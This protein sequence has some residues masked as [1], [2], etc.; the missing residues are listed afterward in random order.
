MPASDI[1]IREREIVANRIFDA[2]RELVWRAFTDPEHLQHWWEPKGFTNTFHVF[3]LKPGG[4]WRFT[5]HGS[6]GRNYENENVFVE[7]DW[8]SRIVFDHVSDPQFRATLGFEALG[9][10]TKLTFHQ[11]FETEAA[12]EFVKPFAVP[13]L[14][15]NL[16]RLAERLPRIDPNFGELTI[17]RIFDAPRAL[18]WRAFTDPAHLAKWWGP[19]GFTNPVCEIDL[20]V[21]G[22]LHIV[23][24]GP[25]GAVSCH[26]MRGIFREI[27]P[28]TRLVFTNCAVGPND[29]VLLDGLTTIEFADRDGKTEMV[30]RT[31]ARG[32]VPGASLMI[33]GMGMGW[34]QSIDKLADFLA[35]AKVGA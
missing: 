20:K 8:L 9:E 3:E 12:F 16:E 6:D 4:L 24:Q 19:K 11:S 25:E 21:G 23:M 7:I 29:E 17:I 33:A 34:T 14:E 2:P 15:Q 18:V 13:G 27:V 32:L 10:K 26:P 5:M 31:S 1:A 28:E 22:A 35:A 30:L